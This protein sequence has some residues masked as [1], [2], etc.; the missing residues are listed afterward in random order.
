M[1]IYIY[2]IAHS[3][4]AG[5]TWTLYSCHASVF[6][7]CNSRGGSGSGSWYWYWWQLQIAQGRT[8]R[9]SVGR[10]PVPDHTQII[11]TRSKSNPPKSAL[12][13]RSERS[14]RAEVPQLLKY[15]KI[16][17]SNAGNRISTERVVSG[18]SRPTGELVELPKLNWLERQRESPY[19][20]LFQHP[21][22]M[23][24]I[25]TPL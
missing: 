13:N 3:L 23:Q 6:M 8:P 19:S 12:P 15:L 11:P 21:F 24:S 20:I 18:R 16:K 1:Y 7:A 9:I 22:I 17:F 4:C 5:E 14:R 25:F 10:R 2:Y